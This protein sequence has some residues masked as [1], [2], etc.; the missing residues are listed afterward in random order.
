[1]TV[2]EGGFLFL[3]AR[4]P[5]TASCPDG[6]VFLVHGERGFDI[7]YRDGKDDPRRAK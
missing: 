1:V 3:P 7:V 6:C 4:L 5:Y 2:E